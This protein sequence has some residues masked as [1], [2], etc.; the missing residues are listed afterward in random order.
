MLQF[1]E[2]PVKIQ[3]QHY[4]FLVDDE[5]FDIKGT[6]CLSASSPVPFIQ[7]GIA[8]GSP[9]LTAAIRSASA[10]GES[11]PAPAPTR[12]APRL[13]TR[14]AG[15]GAGRVEWG[16]SNHD[17]ARQAGCESGGHSQHTGNRPD[18]WVLRSVGVPLHVYDH[19]PNQS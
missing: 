10:T 4:A 12:Q 13:M 18:C 2:P 17:A 16:V 9:D 19:Q 14:K 15:I 1:A 11:W 6:P 8:S 3:M 5:L 7:P